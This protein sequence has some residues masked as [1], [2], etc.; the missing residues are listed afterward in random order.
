MIRPI[1]PADTQAVLDIWNPVIRDTTITFSSE[2]KDP[3]TLGNTLTPAALQGM[4]FGWLARGMARFWVLPVMRSFGAEMAMP[5]QWNIRL[6]WH[7]P[8]MVRAMAGR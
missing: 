6:F 7:Q 3:T 4:I 5:L 2:E 8:R 1:T